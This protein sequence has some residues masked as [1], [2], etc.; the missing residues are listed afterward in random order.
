MYG[1]RVSSNVSI[2]NS[3]HFCPIPSELGG[4]GGGPKLS[5]I[6]HPVFSIVEGLSCPSHAKSGVTDVLK[7]ALANSLLA[8]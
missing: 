4:A 3:I 8:D 6:K 7:F 2:R 5:S 1:S